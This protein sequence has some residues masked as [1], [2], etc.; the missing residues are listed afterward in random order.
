LAVG[1]EE[2]RAIAQNYSLDS[3]PTPITGLPFPPVDV[4][5]LSKLAR[6]AIGKQIGEIG[7]GGPTSSDPLFH[8]R[9]DRCS[10]LLQF[11]RTQLP[12][13][14]GRPNPG[15]E[16]DLVGI[17]VSQ[18]RHD[19]LIE[20]K[21]LD[22]RLTPLEGGSQLGGSGQVS[23]GVSPQLELILQLFRCENGDE[24]E[25]AR[26]NETDLLLL[27]GSGNEMGVGG[28]GVARG[29]DQHSSGHAQVDDERQSGVK[30]AEDEF[31]LTTED[32]D[33]SPC[34]TINHVGR[35]LVSPP[36]PRMAELDLEQAT[37]EQ[38]GFKEPPGGLYF[39]ELG[40]GDKLDLAG[41]DD[42]L[43]GPHVDPFSRFE[44]GRRSEPDPKP[45]AVF[46]GDRDHLVMSKELG[47]EH[48]GG[49][50]PMLGNDH[51]F[52]TDHHLHPVSQV[53]IRAASGEGTKPGNGHSAGD[54][55]G[56]EDRINQER[57]NPG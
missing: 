37:S 38:V 9:G 46:E 19:P 18:T 2:G 53:R 57:G 32:I 24:P 22:R 47:S 35:V 29:A 17:D 30:I 1:A 43:V 33:R 13:W 20:Q 27:V 36:G 26:V 21:V 48:R 55:S 39:G 6:P 15:A 49:T 44:S 52:W 5:P 10:Q 23:I 16:E 4:E 25:G 40:H 3:G 50:V 11:L 31:A 42:S 41:K 8:D 28:L 7:K 56:D 51:V 14:P 54:L 34:Q 45:E 12:A